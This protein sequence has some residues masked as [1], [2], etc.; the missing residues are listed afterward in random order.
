MIIL[1]IVIGAA[2]HIFW[3]DFTHPLGYFV[4]HSTSLRHKL[5][6]LGFQIPVYNIL[7]S[8]SSLIGGLIVCIFISRLPKVNFKFKRQN[9]FYWLF[10]IAIIIIIMI[11]RFLFGLTMAKYGNVI[12]SI[13]SAFFISIIIIPLFILKKEPDINL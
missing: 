2:S 8:I 9:D 4:R 10:V 11:V 5:D 12:V 13:I 7:Q 6:V 3:D 1:S